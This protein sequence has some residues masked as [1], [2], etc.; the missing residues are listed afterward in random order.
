MLLCVERVRL[1]EEHEKRHEKQ[2]RESVK[3]L[4]WAE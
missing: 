3:M 1:K 4:R 2:I